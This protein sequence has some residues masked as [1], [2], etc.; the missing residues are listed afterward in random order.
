MAAHPVP[1][2]WLVFYEL[3]IAKFLKEKKWK[4]AWKI[5]KDPI[6]S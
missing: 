4:V 6:L 2:T 1:Q 3:H 5:P